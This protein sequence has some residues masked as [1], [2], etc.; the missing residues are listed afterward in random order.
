MAPENEKKIDKIAGYYLFYGSNDYMLKQRVSSLIKAV[1]PPGGEVFDL[2]RFDGKRC[3]IA[4]LLNSVSTP[5]AMSPRRI[6]VL[7]KTDKL[8]AKAQNLL[9]DALPKIPE[10]SVLAMTS[11]KADKRSKLFKTL[12][13]D[14][15]TAHEYNDFTHSDAIGLLRQFAGDRGKKIDPGLADAMVGIF[16]TNPYRL[17]NEIE[18]LSLLAGERE[19]IEKKDLAFASGF[20]KIETAYDLPDLVFDGRIK[21]ALELSGR[22]LS[23]GINEIQILYLFKNHLDRLN[24]ACNLRDFKSLMAVYRMPYPVAKVIFARSKRIKA[25]AILNCLSY[26]FK[27][28]YALKSGRFQSRVVI[29]LLVVAIYLASGGNK[30]AGQR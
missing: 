23:S 16:G 19:E 4:A 17:E 14:K 13:A 29:E 20:S 5:P 22:A 2:D 3:D 25:S 1:I 18:K 10:Y 8:Q 7:E 6:T 15:K 21:D 9:C 26:I 27:A 11:G 24:A 30:R 28:E 12:L